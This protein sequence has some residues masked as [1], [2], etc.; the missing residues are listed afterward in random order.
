MQ[1]GYIVFNTKQGNICVRQWDGNA[2]SEK[3]KRKSG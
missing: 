3:A 1:D 2:L